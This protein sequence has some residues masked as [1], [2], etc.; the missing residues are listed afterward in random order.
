MTVAYF[1]PYIITD[2]Y[3]NMAVDEFL[4]RYT[5][6]PSLRFYSFSELSLTIGY[7]QRYSR[8]CDT[9]Y[10]EDN[11]IPVARRITGGR[12]VPHCGDLTY[13]FSSNYRYFNEIIEENSLKARYSKLADGFIKGFRSAGIDIEVNEGES[14]K[15]YGANCF[16]STSLYELSIQGKKI[17]GSAQTFLSDR[18]L[19]QGA[20]LVNDC[21][22]AGAIFGDRIE[23]YN[24]E[25]IS[26][27]PYNIK[28]LSDN[29]Y[30]AF[31]DSFS[32]DW[33][34]FD[35]DFSDRRYLEMIDRYKS[36]EHLRRR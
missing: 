11:N 22:E 26:D 19:Q 16:D 36:K 32:Y 33:K 13:S 23:L 2:V 34:E 10:I 4:Y 8:S 24:I 30:R 27:I 25:K 18:F 14:E 9:D 28:E 6:N 21:P 12:T 20:I 15:P 7:N 17:L 29:F 1:L 31:R 5:D 3:S 35:F